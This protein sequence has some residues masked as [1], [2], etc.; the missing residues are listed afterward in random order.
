[1][2]SMWYIP[3]G[4]TKGQ[5][6]LA[7]IMARENFSQSDVARMLDVQQGSV[8]RWISGTRTP[9]R[10]AAVRILSEFGI[11]VNAWSEAVDEPEHRT[12]EG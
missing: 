1:M 9:D 3:L 12:A 5:T 2:Y 11:P 7:A 6:M 4:M 10:D 8:C